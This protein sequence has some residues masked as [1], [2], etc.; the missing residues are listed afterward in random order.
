MTVS[1]KNSAYVVASAVLSVVFHALLIMAL[2][3]IG[4]TP[5]RAAATP[6]E[7]KSYKQLRI[8]TVDIRDRVFERTDPLKAGTDRLQFKAALAARKVSEIF[9]QAHLL[10]KPEPE[11]T[12]SGLGQ[13][14]LTPKLPDLPPPAP[15]APEPPRIVEIDKSTLPAE[16]L[17]ERRELSARKERQDLVGNLVPGLITG[18]GGA[19][20]GGD[21][22]HLSMRLGPPAIPLRA[23]EVPDSP[24][25]RD[26]LQSTVPSGPSP[27]DE[28]L[29]NRGSA[30]GRLD[31]LVSITMSV[32]THPSGDVYFQMAIAPNAKSDRLRAIPKDVLFVVDC[33][34]SIL[35]SKLDQFKAG[36]DAALEYLNPQDRLNVVSFRSAPDAFFN[37]FEPVTPVSLEAARNYVRRLE[38]G[39]LTDVYGGIAPYVTSSPDAA[40]RPL[41]VFLLTDG[42]ST[43]SNRVD[44]ETFIRQIAKLRQAHVSIY[45][46]SAGQEAN[47]FL[48]DLLAY[49]NRGSSMHQAEVKN[50]APSLGRFISDHSEMIVADL[51]YQATGEIARDF[52]PKQLPHLYRNETL[53][54]YGRCPSGITTVGIQLLGRDADHHQQ[55]LVFLGYL[56][57]APKGTPEIAQNWASQKVFFLLTERVIRPTPEAAAEIRRTAE[58]FKLYVP[59][60]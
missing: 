13:N 34:T 52:Y 25:R 17:T 30:A 31:A 18:D 26:A 54:I 48:M 42:K 12:L 44:N 32:Y 5:F 29:G 55:E 47:R 36:V 56:K 1:R 22:I 8:Q 27:L 7:K 10:P 23:G 6:T 50:F 39:G 16:R 37:G 2:A 28:N 11:V 57:T 3:R 59:Y 15:M 43:V 45:S 20:G 38:R 4:V 46:F 14:V 33:S 41:N 60:L 9:E 35:P 40:G 51:R 21:S 19:G 24:Q 58:Q 49:S 53:H